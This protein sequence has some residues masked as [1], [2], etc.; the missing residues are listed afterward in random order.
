[1]LRTLLLAGAA[2]VG[3]TSA[4]QAL[5]ISDSDSFSASDPW[6]QLLTLDKFDTTLGILNSI[7]FTIEGETEG[8]VTVTNNSANANAEVEQYRIRSRITVTIPDGGAYSVVSQPQS[9]L[10]TGPVLGP[11][12]VFN[13]PVGGG[14]DS[15][16][17][18]IAFAD[19]GLFSQAGGGTFQVLAEAIAASFS[20]VIGPAF[21][22]SSQTDSSVTVTVSYDYDQR[23]IT[24]PEPASLALLGVG[25]VGL[26]LA[27]RR[28]AA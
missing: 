9:A 25:L 21:T 20:Q 17:V 27:R 26:G 23:V 19:F 12:G 3:M 6:S 5:I 7:T 8:S 13:S 2:V 24:T 4:A 28:K 14:S 18:N 15:D 22:A 1:M 16:I 11:L 10:L